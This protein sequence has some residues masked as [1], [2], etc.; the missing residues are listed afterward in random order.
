MSKLSKSA[1][2]MF[3][4]Q[5]GSELYARIVKTIEKEN[6]SSLMD[7]GILVGLSGGADSVFLLRFL[8][9]YKRREEFEPEIPVLC[10]RN[11]VEEGIKT[12][13][14]PDLCRLPAFPESHGNIRSS[15]GMLQ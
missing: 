10:G 1:E 15:H 5:K 3:A 7:K 2:T 4:S 14:N 6:M 13:E 12:A 9:E 11:S 8:R